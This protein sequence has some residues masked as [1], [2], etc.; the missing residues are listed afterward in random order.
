MVKFSQ[1]F[2]ATRATSLQ[3]SI[4]IHYCAQF[5][6]QKLIKGKDEQSM[7]IKLQKKNPWWACPI[8]LTPQKIA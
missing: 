4:N 6:E 3:G 7:A 2:H 8:D 1:G 5:M